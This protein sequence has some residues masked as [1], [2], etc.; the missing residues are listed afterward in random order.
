[1]SDEENRWKWN[2]FV[3]IGNNIH[4]LRGQVRILEAKRA[5]VFAMQLIVNEF[6]PYLPIKDQQL[7]E[8]LLHVIAEYLDGNAEVIQAA[9]KD[10]FLFQHG[11]AGLDES[12]FDIAFSPKKAASK[13]DYLVMST[14]ELKLFAITSRR[15]NTDQQKIM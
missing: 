3:E 13:L 2:K 10:H 8:T 12:L 1:M 9:V 4:K 7:Y 5:L 6:I 11:K 14:M 15:I